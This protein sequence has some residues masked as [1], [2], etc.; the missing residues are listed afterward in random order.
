VLESGPVDEVTR[1]GGVLRVRLAAPIDVEAL[2]P[3]A[4]F[5]PR[6]D[7]DV[8]LLELG[9]RDPAEVNAL[10]LPHLVASGARIVEVRLGE[11]LESAYLARRAREEASSS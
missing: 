10:A 11:S 9:D 3:L 7:G 6:V 8:L 2:E 1:K 5:A 4:P